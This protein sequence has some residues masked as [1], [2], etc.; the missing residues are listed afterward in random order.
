M[1]ARDQ[2]MDNIMAFWK[3]RVILTACNFD[4][5]TRIDQSP[6]SAKQIAAAQG[7]DPFA[8][9]RLLNSLAAMGL[10]DKKED[11]FHLTPQGGLLS[12]LQPDSM[13]AM[14]LHFNDVWEKWSDL[15][16][17][18]KEGRHEKQQTST[19]DKKTLESFIGA[20]DAI[21]RDLAVEIAESF[22]ASPFR[23]LLDI[24]GGSGTYTVAFLNKNPGLT[25]VLFDLEPVV[26][27]AE[28]RLRADGLIDRVHLTAGDF[29]R[30]ELPAGC[31]LALLSAI[32]HQNNPLQ[33]LDLFM[34]IFR[35]LNPGGTLLIRDHIMN[36]TRTDPPMGAL[37]ALNMLV[38]TPGGDTYSFAEL[39]ESLN[40][41][42]FEIVRQIRQGDR[43]DGL[44][45]AQKPEV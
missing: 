41:A 23:R 33:N 2:L 40:Q 19:R 28:K 29:Y 34:K 43:M 5:F 17:V 22:N 37:F 27:I 31:D 39:K 32:I 13:L 12:S 24:G 16:N 11:T 26:T 14:A 35:A 4:V 36:E 10:L 45:A 15:T 21:A 7:A 44:I 9:E 30:D 18:V 6:G 25:A 1:Q 8:M 20:M 42:G 3:S 38:V